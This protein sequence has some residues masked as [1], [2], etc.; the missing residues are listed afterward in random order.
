MAASADVH[1]QA[2]LAADV[3]SLGASLFSIDRL[4]KPAV[5][6]KGITTPLG[7]VRPW[8]FPD[9]ES[10]ITACLAPTLPTAP[11]PRN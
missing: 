9:F 6:A 3:W 11:P 4:D 1:V 10:T 8:P 7:D 2:Q 5:I